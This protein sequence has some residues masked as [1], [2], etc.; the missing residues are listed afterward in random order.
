MPVQANPDGIIHALITNLRMKHFEPLG[1][2][3]ASKKEISSK[4]RTIAE[5][6]HEEVTSDGIPMITHGNQ[7]KTIPERSMAHQ[8]PTEEYE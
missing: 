2:T 6:N 3:S 7:I 5:N 1:P 4:Q 8:T